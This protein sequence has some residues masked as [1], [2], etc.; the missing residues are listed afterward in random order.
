MYSLKYLF[1][2]RITND[3]IIIPTQNDNHITV[4]DF[5]GLCM[6]HL[7]MHCVAN[8]KVYTSALRF[9]FKARVA[10]VVITLLG[11]VTIENATVAVYTRT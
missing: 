7:Y 11:S 9:T 3:N 8:N 2:D 10:S 1:T 5:I 4:S 6:L